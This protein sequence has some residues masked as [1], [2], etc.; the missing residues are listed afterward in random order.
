MNAVTEEPDVEAHEAV[1]G[2]ERSHHATQ[3]HHALARPAAVVVAVLAALLAVASLLASGAASA[4]LL[5][6]QRASDTYNEMEA[7]S[8]KRHM[9][10]N[11]SSLLRA[12]PAPGGTATAA[13]TAA[14]R[15][16]M[17][18]SAKYAAAED[19][20]LPV[21]RD[22]EHRRD[23]AEV[24]DHDYH[25]SEVTLQIAIVLVSVAILAGSA[26]LVFAGGG[27]GLLGTALLAD[28]YWSFVHLPV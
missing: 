18:A 25:L 19:R 4:V 2:V 22:L 17:A 3:S 20:L 14:T 9:N 26:P 13:L 5:D 23:A 8:L 27:L 7:N 10:E 16:D 12:I 24:Q 21:A 6:Q 1:E 28:G 11:T 15:L